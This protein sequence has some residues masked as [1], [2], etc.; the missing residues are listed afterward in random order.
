MTIVDALNADKWRA[1]IRDF[2][3]KRAR[4]VS[5]VA[6]LANITGATPELESERAALV[7]KSLLLQTQVN[8]L[9]GA[10]KAVRD[11]LAKIAQVFSFGGVAPGSLGGLGIA[12][13]VVGGVTIAGIAIV[14][15]AITAWLQAASA[16]RGKNELAKTLASKGASPKE[17]ADAVNAAPKDQ[18]EIFGFKVGGLKW[19]AIIAGIFIAGPYLVKGF[20]RFQVTKLLK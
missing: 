13:L 12:P 15:N 20:E 16:W 18:P 10:L 19:V 8:A 7:K 4:F 9:H 14:A 5:F 6:E 17:I 1:A 11:F 3:A 2:D